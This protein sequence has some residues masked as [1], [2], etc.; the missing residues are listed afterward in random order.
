MKKVDEIL[1]LKSRKKAWLSNKTKKL[2]SEWAIEANKLDNS[3]T[4]AEYYEMF[5]IRLRFSYERSLEK[6]QFFKI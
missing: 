6:K 4:I 2:F 1:K 3:K 5:V